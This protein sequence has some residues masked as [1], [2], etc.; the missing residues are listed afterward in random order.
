MDNKKSPKQEKPQKKEVFS[1]DHAQV[2]KIQT[3]E[4]WKREQLKHRKAKS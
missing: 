1:L 2:P 3:A 4:G